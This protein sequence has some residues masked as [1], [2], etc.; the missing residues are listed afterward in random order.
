MDGYIKN[1][2]RKIAEQRKAIRWSYCYTF[3]IV[4]I[5]FVCMFGLGYNAPPK[6]WHDIQVV[7]SRVSKHTVGRTGKNA[8]LHTTDGQIFLIKSRNYTADEAEEI[9]VP[10]KTYQLTYSNSMIYKYVEA[11]STEEEILISLEESLSKYESNNKTGKNV[12]V[13]LVAVEI[14]ALILID[15]LGC[16]K[17]YAE[18]KR[19]KQ[20]IAIREEK[21]RKRKEK[22]AKNDS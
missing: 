12:F 9:L 11:L 13:V 1:K 15:R 8:F 3:P 21:L 20:D 22:Q 16:K 10:G 5:L 4:M 17:M 19:L 7:C 6:Q 18:I 2:Q 14:V